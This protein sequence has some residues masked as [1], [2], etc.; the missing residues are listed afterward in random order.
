MAV[1]RVD[2]A[3]GR[4]PVPRRRDLDTA[5]GAASAADEPAR[6]R[7]EEQRGVV[8]ARHEDDPVRPG[9]GELRQRVDFGVVRRQ[10]TLDAGQRLGF[11]APDVRG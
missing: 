4:Y 8:I 2:L 9:A 11:A 7:W 6:D 3:I 10:H 5:G 1:L